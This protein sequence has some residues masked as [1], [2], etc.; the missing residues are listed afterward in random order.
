MAFRVFRVVFVDESKTY[1]PFGSA[2]ATR[3]QAEAKRNELA[4]TWATAP[5]AGAEAT[6]Q[7]ALSWYAF[8]VLEVDRSGTISAEQTIQE[9]FERKAV[10]S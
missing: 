2:Y 6:G 7:S 5:S 8:E 10:Q 9:S 4:R 1:V 3:E